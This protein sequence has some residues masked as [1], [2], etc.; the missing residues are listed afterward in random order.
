MPF[1]F[2]IHKGFLDTVLAFCLCLPFKSRLM[3]NDIVYLIQSFGQNILPE[4]ISLEEIRDL[5]GSI[6]SMDAGRDAEDLV[7]FLEG[8]AFGLWEEE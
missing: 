3:I 4:D 6:C 7:Q 1:W 5:A 8:L 2:H